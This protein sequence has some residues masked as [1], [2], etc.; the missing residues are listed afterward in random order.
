MPGGT[1]SGL[2][3]GG[4]VA[5]RAVPRAPAWRGRS[6]NG[7]Q[8]GRWG[9]GFCGLR[10][11]RGG[12]RGRTGTR[13]R[14]GRRGYVRLIAPAFAPVLRAGTGTSPPTVQRCRLPAGDTVRYGPDPGRAQ[15]AGVLARS[16]PR[17]AASGRDGDRYG[18]SAAPVRRSEGM[19]GEPPAGPGA[20]NGVK[21]LRDPRRP[22]RGRLTANDKARP[23][24]SQGM[25]GRAGGGFPCGGPGRGKVASAREIGVPLRGGASQ[26][27]ARPVTQRP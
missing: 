26:A 2:S 7:L 1:D 11:C 14:R 15:G 6:V 13:P 5:G 22:R 10:G 20:D 24:R 9:L 16:L 19:S 21:N 18:G 3:A 17:G 8:G 27:G 12:R 25:V 4:V 23:G